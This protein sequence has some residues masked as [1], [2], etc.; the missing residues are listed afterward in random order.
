MAGCATNP[1]GTA[2]RVIDDPVYASPQRLVEV[3]PNRRLNLHCT[4]SG[5]PTVVFD[6]S[7]AAETSE[8]GL[9]QPVVARKTRACSYDR[10]GIGFS[11]AA[12]RPGSSANIVD[13]LHRLLV[14]A[15][16]EPPY[17]LVGHSYGGMN[18]K[19]YAHLHTSEVVGMVFVDPSHEDQRSRYRR[20]NPKQ[21]TEAEYDKLRLEPILA[22][23]REC[24]AAA[25]AGFTPGTPL[26]GKCVGD[27]DA[28]FS[29]AIN[30]AH[31]KKYAQVAYQQ[32]A[33]NEEEAI[34][35]ASA[36]QLRAARRSLGDVPIIVL[37]SDT[38][39]V[40][41]TNPEPPNDPPFR[42][43]MVLHDDIAALSSRGSNRIVPRTGHLVH[44]DQ[45]QAVSDAI[46]EVLS[47]VAGK[48]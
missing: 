43:W 30:A 32:A 46:F 41:S 28:R 9:V 44:T 33:M 20:L 39:G 13:D 10:A 4:G 7:L 3:E 22:S 2:A 18:I 24:I 26:Y 27:P 48:K 11:D 12:N 35:H 23:H 34:Y 1:I 19:L 31:L 45:P 36:E 8:W 17:V 21:P 42:L 25:P 29:E 40:A 14:A 47:M 38:R 15:A 16:I 37:T 6:S 5:S